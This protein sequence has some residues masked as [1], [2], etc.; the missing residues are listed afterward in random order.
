MATNVGQTFLK[1]LDEEFRQNQ[2]F[3]KIFNRNTVKISYSCMPNLE[4]TIDGNNRS[5]LLKTT[6]KPG[7]RTCNCRI[8]T[9][10]PVAGNFLKSSVVYQATITTDNSMPAQTYVGHTETPLKIRFA[11]H[12]STFNS[13]NKRLSAELSTHVWC[14]KEAGLPFKIS[15]K[16]LYQTS[17]S[18]PVSN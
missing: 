10:C 1:I 5:I 12:K 8:P 13:P 18:N 3:H 14:L 15:W 4:K 11:H 9:D 17:P 2:V 6:T 16:F 7:L